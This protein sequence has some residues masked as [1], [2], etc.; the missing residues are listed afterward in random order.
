MPDFAVGTAF[1]SKDRITQAFKKMTAGASK[2]GRT[3]ENA[4]HRASR[5]GSR[6]KDI[7]KGILTAGAVSKGLGLLSRGLQNVTTQYVEFDDEIFGA[8]AR[9]KA[10]EKA[11]T[12]MTKVMEN[13]RKAARK[14]GA[15]TQF[16]AAQAAFGLN[17]FALA[18]FTSAEAI[19]ALRSQVDLT[20]VT[21]EEFG[22]VTDISSDLLGAFG[23][24]ALES[25]KKIEMLKKMNALLAVGTLSANVTMEDLF[26]TLKSAAPIGTALGKSMADVIATTSVLGSAGIKGS[27]AATALKNIFLR[28]AAPTKE[29]NAALRELNLRQEH[30]INNRGK[31]K[32][33]AEIFGIIGDK[34]KGMSDVK[35][36][37]LFKSLAGL[38]GIAGAANISKN[39]GQIRE[40][41]IRMS[42][43]PQKA[44]LE[45][46]EMMRKSLGNRLKTLGSAATELGFKFLEAFDGEGRKGMD[47]LTAAIRNFNVKPIIDT[48]KF[49]LV[50]FKTILPIIPYVIAGFVAFKTALLAVAIAT[51]IWAAVSAVAALS[52]TTFGIAVQLLAWP[53]TLTILAIAALVAGIILLVKNWD[54][55]KAAFI[56]STWVIDKYVRKTFFTLADVVLTIFGT[57]TKGIVMLMSKIG[58]FI[59]FDTSGLDKVVNKIT[60]LQKTVRKESIFGPGKKV[61]RDVEAFKKE[62]A[63]NAE[64]VKAIQEGRFQADINFS[65]LP[66][67]AKVEKKEEGVAFL[68]LNFLGVNP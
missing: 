26:E 19:K 24:A 56:K 14:T 47:S 36:A 7:T 64:K 31:L 13:L 18:G 60:T 53:I 55:V 35:V 62:K 20:T 41:M 9:F 30:F 15:D 5:A 29:V 43:D 11:G 33:T 1:T 16:T 52:T 50:I 22:R 21:G 65:N 42:K 25:S 59:G 44:M 48:L 12:D 4:F 10:A 34:T 8:T 61:K 37:A 23:G 45:T 54:V 67:E 40:Q 49:I 58:K 68:N 57:I 2:F 3:S 39:I 17:K 32:S 46:A 66:K 63:P 38:R 28:L 27:E 6:F 51:K